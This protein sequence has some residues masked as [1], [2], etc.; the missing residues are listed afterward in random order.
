[1]NIDNK[2]I[3]IEVG[4]NQGTDT[5]NYVSE[6]VLLYAFEPVSVLAYDLVNKFKNKN[7][8][9]IP[10]A[11]DIENGIKKF[12]VSAGSNLGCSSLNNFNKNIYNEWRDRSDFIFTESYNV[13][14]IRLDNF[15]ELY[16]IKEI[17]Y[18]HIDA[19]GNDF[20]VIKSLANKINLVKAG[21]CE[22]AYTVNL[23]EEV[24]NY[25]EN[26]VKYLESHGF[27]TRIEMDQSGINAE[28]DIHFFK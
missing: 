17:E 24:D 13:L 26:I 15:I 6:D 16:N 12:N 8:I 25:Y 28:C 3:Y 9:V 23:Y 5:I 18:L 21:K 19:Q 4:A 10:F 14:T 22:A 2:K 1:M 11:V 20:N 7:V 27:K